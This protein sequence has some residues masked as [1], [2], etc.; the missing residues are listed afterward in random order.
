MKQIPKKNTDE[1]L[2]QEFLKNG[3]K[4]FDLIPCL[5]DSSDHIKLFK[6]LVKKY[7]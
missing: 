2:V 1:E 5:N 4:N 7:L 3:G 6:E